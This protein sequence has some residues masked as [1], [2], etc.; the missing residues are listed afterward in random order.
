MAFMK[1]W[2]AFFHTIRAK[3][4]FG[5]FILTLP[6]IAMLIY[7]NF[8]AIK[9]VRNQVAHSYNQMTQMYMNQIDSSMDR[10]EIY[11]N[12]IVAL[13]QDFIAM[14]QTSSD[15]IYSLSKLMLSNR[16]FNDI[17][18]YPTAKSFIVYNDLRDDF[19]DVTNESIDYDKKL[20]I[21]DFIRGQAAEQTSGEYHAFGWTVKQIDNSYYLIHTLK[22]SNLYVSAI[23]EANKLMIPFHLLELGE[24]GGVLLA[25]GDGNAITN[26]ELVEASGIHLRPQQT[27]YDLTGSE[28]KFLIVGEQSTNGNFSLIVVIPDEQILQNLP[29]MQRILLVF[30]A[31]TLLLVPLG[32]FYLRKTILIPLNKLLMAMR[33]IRSGSLTT[34]VETASITNEFQI[35]NTTFNQ[36]VDEI[37]QLKL[38]VYEEQLNKQKEELLRLQLQMNPHFFM[39][40]LTILYNLA[41]MNKT[42]LMME[43]TMCLIQHF[44]F[45]FRSNSTFVMLRDELEHS[46]NYLRI[47]ELRFP[48]S[49]ASAIKVPDYVMDVA[50]PPL[51]IQSFF[52]NIVKHAVTLEEPICITLEV[53]IMESETK[54]FIVLRIEDTGKGYPEHVLRAISKGIS[55]VN[56]KGE[57]TGIWNIQRRIRLLYEHEG[58]IRFSNR[59]PHGAVVEMK[60]PMKP[61]KR[62]G[63]EPIV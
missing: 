41:K 58:H 36:M 15:D 7:N 14:V 39:N 17:N 29:T 54:P 3:L 52:E 34:K 49:I 40:S 62:Q 8:Y 6:M 42:N 47:Q 51:I 9:V 2:F 4:I 33:R 63:G 1:K 24:H 30:P 56:N 59:L 13:D 43:M 25:D 28:Q 37:R 53:D 16:M 20:E 23:I 21:N 19:I 10:I 38:D 60:L 12:N 18:M 26:A 48:G 55:I 35:V 61:E 5:V 45:I 57:H 46:R 31:L 50:V 27:E 44:R 32:L 22:Y 11:M